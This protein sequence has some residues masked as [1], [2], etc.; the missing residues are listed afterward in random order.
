M[1]CD[2]LIPRPG[3]LVTRDSWDRLQLPRNSVSDKQKITGWIERYIYLWLLQLVTVKW[4]VSFLFFPPYNFVVLKAACFDYKLGQSVL[5]YIQ[6]LCKQETGCPKAP[7]TSFSII[8]HVPLAF[9]PSLCDLT[10]DWI[11]PDLVS[12]VGFGFEFF[13]WGVIN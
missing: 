8:S 12:Q 7:S 2:R 11:I 9:N 6:V 1:S 5:F 13:F 3:G 10:L 4:Y